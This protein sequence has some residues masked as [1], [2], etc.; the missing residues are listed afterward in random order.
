MQAR[1][2]EFLQSGASC[3]LLLCEDDKEALNLA[4]VAKFMGFTPFVL[5]DFRAEL[6]EDLKPYSKELFKLCAVLSA[7][8]NEAQEALELENSKEFKP[9]FAKEHLKTAAQVNL[10][11]NLNT[12]EILNQN[13]NS[14]KNV[15]SSKKLLIS[16]IRTALHKLPSKE[17]LKNLRLDLG[18]KLDLKA[19]KDSLLRMG[20]N[21]VDMVQDKGEV[22]FR[23]DIMDIFAINTQAPFRILFFDDEIESI[24]VFDINTQRSIK[25]E[26]KSIFICPFL[27]FLN[28]RSYENLQEKLAS[29]TQILISDINSQGFWCMNDFFDYLS[30]DFR[31]IK[32]FD[33]REIDK[34]LSFINAKVLPEARNYKDLNS[35]YSQDFFSFHKDKKIII[36]ARNE[37]LLKQKN[38]DLKELGAS[39]L[40]ENDL[41]LNEILNTNLNSI[42]SNIFFIQSELYLNLISSKL[43]ICSFNSLKK[44]KI[45]NK[46]PSLLIDELKKCDFVSHEDY[47]VGKFL[48]LERIKIAGAQK[49]FI[50][51]LYQNNDKLLLPV[52]NLYLIDK[53]IG[54]NA[55]PVLD[56]LGKTSFLKL[57]ARLKEKLLALA[58]ELIQMAA[59]RALIMPKKLVV[60]E[61][62]QQS[63]IQSAPFEYT[64]DQ[65]KSVR[66]IL[67]DFKSSHVMDRLLSGDVGFGKTE[68]AMNALLCVL[69]NNFTAFFF[70]PTTLLCQQHFKSLK[71]RLSAFDIE[72][73]RLDRFTNT[74]DKKLILEYLKTN[75]PCVVVGTHSLLSIK[76]ENLAL[77][78]IDEEHKFGVKQKEKLKEFSKEAH[79]LSMSATPIPR[80]LNQALS[81]IKTYSVLSTP[82][83]ERLDVRSFVKENDEA[84]IKE[85]I[86]RELRRGGQIFYIHN[87]IA[88]IQSCAKM[89]K[90]LVPS[91]R[92]LILH[93]KIESKS[94][95]EE[96]LKFEDKQY[97]LLLS[98]SIV[99]SGI[100]LPNA[101]TIIIE[102]AHKFGMADLHQ[103]RGRVGRSDR[104]AYCYFLI[105]DKNALSEEALKRLVSLESNSFLGAGSILAM[106][107]LEIRGGGNL[108]GVDQSGHIEQIG[109][110]LYL[111]M[112]EDA[113]NE[114]SKQNKE[115]Q[116]CELKLNVS[117]FLNSDLIAEDNLRLELYKRLS[118]CE[119]VNEVYEIEGEIND[120]F[121]ALDSYTKRFLELIIIKILSKNRFKMISNFEANIQLTTLNDEKIFLKAEYKD[122]E[123][124]IEGILEFLRKKEK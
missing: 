32:S 70:V 80:S 94:A 48:G 63:F 64:K 6:N 14:N 95:E 52:E 89:L 11:E 49:E 26:L 50:S 100:D 105:P 29:N 28:E 109:Y 55:V 90:E 42:N 115:A 84:L 66:E 16:P 20:Y 106:H 19:L 120:R 46:K 59:A 92:I 76:C 68:V 77:V 78:I 61:V 91:L 35:S 41:N 93:S 57:K 82:P 44:T 18:Q 3:E 104:Q 113:L 116:N 8:H 117:A 98:T 111:K 73:F 75:K 12:D 7:Y 88:S 65:E 13:L 102:N 39:F 99:E 45:R 62:L 22:S 43:I 40:N 47:G 69:K 17:N 30:L 51:L 2:F 81:K 21:F 15:K 74:K 114:L 9:S 112:L 23:G 121:G 83:S 103:L 1:L 122:D 37:A 56:K 72:I 25:E 96:M 86:L 67:S 119:S 24:R 4:E 5:P 87:H 85:A 110:A 97:D 60:D 123:S 10:N 27:A 108:L 31:A 38:I 36:L 107:D 101:N 53:F 79:I 118:K 33:E 34:N 71:A 54:T 124:V 58:N